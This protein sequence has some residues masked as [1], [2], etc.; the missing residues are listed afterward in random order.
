MHER[1]TDSEDR[2]INIKESWDVN[3]WCDELNLRAD[4]LS[5]IVKEVGP[6]P[7]DV[8]LYITKKLLLKWP[9]SY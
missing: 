9:L 4:E 2:L 7:H 6:V 8:R 5:E 3:Y 1:N